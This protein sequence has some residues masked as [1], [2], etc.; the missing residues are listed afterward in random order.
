MLH[1]RRDHRDRCPM[2]LPVARRKIVGRR[3]R[4]VRRVE[5]RN[6][7]PRHN[8]LIVGE[9]PVSRRETRGRLQTR[10][11]KPRMILVDPGIDDADLDPRACV[12]A[13]AN[14]APR[15]RHPHQVQRRIQHRLGRRQVLHPFHARNV[16]QRGPVVRR[17]SHEYCVHQHLR[18]GTHLHLSPAQL[19]DH[20]SLRPTHLGQMRLRFRTLQG[21]PRL[22]LLSYRRVFEDQRVINQSV[23]A[24]RECCRHQQHQN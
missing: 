9:R 22:S 10:I 1:A 23:A 11:L 21:C 8:H 19:R 20:G 12:A 18:R 24:L 6:I 7:T 2:T 13:A 5:Q 3:N 15:R 16:F 17:H 14:Q 4:R